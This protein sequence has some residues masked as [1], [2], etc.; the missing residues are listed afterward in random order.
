MSIESDIMN[1]GASLVLPDLKVNGSAQVLQSAAAQASQHVPANAEIL[2][3]ELLRQERLGSSGIG[4]GI[5]ILHLQLPALSEP[6]VMLS[7]L[8]ES[9]EFNAA[10]GDPVDLVLLLLSPE[11]DGPMHLCRLA[12]LSRTFRNEKLCADLRAART[13]DTMRELLSVPEDWQLAA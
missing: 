9:V 10:D 2:Y 12:Q 5:A 7:R 6:F 13:E 1:I 3:A 11:S 4:G 8:S